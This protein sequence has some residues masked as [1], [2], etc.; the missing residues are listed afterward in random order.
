MIGSQEMSEF[1]TSNIMCYLTSP[2]C[3]RMHRI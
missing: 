2:A 3:H 1:V